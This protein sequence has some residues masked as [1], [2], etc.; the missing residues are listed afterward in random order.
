MSGMDDDTRQS[1]LEFQERVQGEREQVQGVLGTLQE[2]NQVP[3][4]APLPETE[5]TDWSVTGEVGRAVW[6]ATVD[7][8]QN[9]VE[10]FRDA[11][12][13]LVPIDRL[14]VWGT[15]GDLN[16]YEIN[17]DAF[18]EGM[19]YEAAKLA[20][21]NRTAAGGIARGFIQF[22]LPYLG[23]VKAANAVNAARGV[24]QA[25][26]LVK[27]YFGG[28]VADMAAF[29]PDD[30]NLS[31]LIQTLEP[32][33]IDIANPVNE[34]LATSPDDTD[35]ENQLRNALEGFLLGGLVD[36]A[37]TVFK[38]MRTR[39]AMK[40]LDNARKNVDQGKA[41]EFLDDVDEAAD[42][43]A[44][45]A[46]EAEPRAET[47]EADEAVELVVEKKP[48]RDTIRD[49]VKITPEQKEAIELAL[50]EDRV[51]DIAK[52]VDFNIE[53][54]DWDSIEDPEQIKA[55]YET[56]SEVVAEQIDL[57]KGG[58]QS[59]EKSQR[60]A[61]LVGVSAEQTHK[62]FRDVRG[63]MGLTARMIAGERTLLASAQRLRT[64]AKKAKSEAG[65]NAD[66]L[67]V[68]RQIELHAGLM[69]EV[70]G[71]KTEIAR[72]M[73]A[74]QTMTAASE[75]SFKEFDDIRRHL[76]AHGDHDAVLDAILQSRNLDELN[77]MV[78]KTF[79]RRITDVV[80]EAVIN[81]LL[82]NPATHALNLTSN[83]VNSVLTT[84]DRYIAA[85]LARDKNLL[86][87]AN[88]DFMAKM[89]MLLDVQ[90][91]ASVSPRG[92]LEDGLL[93]TL[94]D[95]SPAFNNAGKAFKQGLPITDVKQRIEFDTRQAIGMSTEGTT[96]INRAFRQ[97]I[98]GL[99]ATI[100][101]PGRFLMAG[102]E[103][104]KTIHQRG[105]LAAEAYLIA[106]KETD[107][108][109]LKGD[110][111]AAAHRK[112]MRELIAEPTPE[113][114]SRAIERARYA[115]FQEGAQGPLGRGM[116]AFINSNPLVKLILAPFY[117][118]PMNLLRQAFLDRTALAFTVSNIRHTLAQGGE[119][120][121]IAMARMTTG[122]AAIGGGVMLVMAGGPDKD[123]EVVG[124]RGSG[125]TEK[126]DG[127]QDYMI[128]LGDT[129]YTFS[130]LDPIGSWLGLSADLVGAMR[131]HTIHGGDDELLESLVSAA[132][133]STW[134]NAMNKTWTK[135]V[136]D[137]QNSINTLATAKNPEA[138]KR[139]IERLAGQQMVKLVPYSSALRAT[140]VSQVD[141]VI[142]DSWEAF[143]QITKIL[144]WASQDLPPGRD[145][146]G[147]ELVRDK[148]EQYWWNPFRI[149]IES[150][151]VLDQELSRLGPIYPYT[152]PDKELDGIPLT[153]AQ[154]SELIRTIGQEPLFG[155]KNLEQLMRQFV[156]SDGYKRAPSDVM[157]VNLLK[158]MYDTAKRIGTRKFKKE[159]GLTG[160]SLE[161]E[162]AE[163]D[164]KL[165]FNL[166]Q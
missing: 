123:F 59:L 154:H 106:A 9:S 110:R 50:E 126:L 53:T 95:V 87:A 77:V 38:G 111:W 163:R 114:Q 86:R 42:D 81:G 45:Q 97:G 146:L 92:V 31:N 94:G 55:I 62:L 128:R 149:S 24:P 74:M 33:G 6:G 49:S 7:A 91:L 136:Q 43:V 162:Q 48:L 159:Q 98:N 156:E 107:L 137:I 69:A 121:A 70:K 100:R 32:F 47:S 78:T 80:S 19:E 34:F 143:D 166:N 93:K 16:E 134:N 18:D 108:R 158:G 131:Y 22:M 3:P 127:V 133:Y 36:G 160:L 141:P 2:T 40:E 58:V 52:L 161:N 132:V 148:A 23:T 25:S 61:R 5:D 28:A 140:T 75:L 10:F 41:T 21:E 54:I 39:N 35:A 113:L 130:R 129:W 90:Q 12:R 138:R 27:S 116:E 82:S 14:I 11:A 155:N 26:Q 85:G 152:E 109:G 20:P 164:R 72:A 51:E 153:P 71:A 65:T 66:R 73:R 56:F 64:L 145:M 151:D 60:M 44:K 83:V 63:N 99:G 144:P 135:S 119:E 88:A 57:S 8:T 125:T 122:T 102:D 124:K 37:M 84:G 147:R 29:D 165:N 117:R 76:G 68:H 17:I 139:A 1:F 103:F 115:T 105:E 157:R 30:G 96:G 46:D 150:Q 142:R 112:R 15:G 120:A 101:L 67:A 104:F 79:G 4:S 89:S 13:T 118:T